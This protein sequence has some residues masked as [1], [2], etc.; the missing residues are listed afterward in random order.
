MKKIYHAIGNFIKNIY[1]YRHILIVDKQFD[2]GYLLTIEQTKLKLMIDCLSKVK[3]A[4]KN[5]A[6]R[7][8]KIC[9]KL[10]DIIND[11]DSALTCVERC[12]IKF[13][14]YKY[15]NTQNASRFD[16]KSCD[17]K[18]I[19]IQDVLRQK[20]AMYLYNIIRCRYMFTWWY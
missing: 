17:T 20:K 18:S 12:P 10:I 5:A 4:D 7:W 8:M 2:Y 15:V 14:L 9:I 3:N 11:N 6:I 1:L 19:F 13:D 16:L